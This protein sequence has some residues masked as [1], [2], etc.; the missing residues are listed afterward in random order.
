MT[1]SKPAASIRVAPATTDAEIVATLD[2]MRELRPHLLPDAYVETV[3]RMMATDG[4]RLAV[5]S[6]DGKVRAVA[7]Y[8][9]MEMLWCGRVL[10]VDDLSTTHTHRSHG[11]GKALLDWLKRE[12]RASGCTQLHLDSGVQ[13]EA[14]HRFYF[15]ERMIVSAFHFRVPIEPA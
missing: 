6:G 2:V 4:Y 13:R 11:Y 1:Q 7:G 15:R 5:A 3:R 10:Y 9:Y 12:A 8:R 14:A